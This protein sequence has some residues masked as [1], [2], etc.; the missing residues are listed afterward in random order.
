ME[1][2]WSISLT[3]GIRCVK[4]VDKTRCSMQARSAAPT[5]RAPTPHAPPQPFS[6]SLPE[7]R[8]AAA[9]CC[10]LN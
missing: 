6:T 4:A 1:E 10:R 9:G 5:A 3:L 7:S 2:D 8:P